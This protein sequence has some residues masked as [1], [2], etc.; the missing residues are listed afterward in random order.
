MD[1]KRISQILH[2]LTDD[3]E[4]VDVSS[5]DDALFARSKTEEPGA[6]I[7]PARA[8]AQ[9]AVDAALVSNIK[10]VEMLSAYMQAKFTL[11]KHDRPHLL[12]F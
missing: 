6:G 2:A 1:G 3:Y 11:N 5:I 9:A 8:S 10:K 4:G 7:D 12:K